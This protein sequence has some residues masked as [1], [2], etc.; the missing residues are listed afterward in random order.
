MKPCTEKLDSAQFTGP[1]AITICRLVTAAEA[2]DG[3]RSKAPVAA[4]TTNVACV[5]LNV[6]GTTCDWACGSQPD[7]APPEHVN[8]MS[9][10]P[11]GVL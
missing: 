6:A 8:V 10:W 3:A 9:V 4:G 2:F 1:G 5:P 7:A 11:V